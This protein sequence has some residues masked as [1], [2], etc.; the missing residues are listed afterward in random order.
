MGKKHQVITHYMTEH[1]YIPLWVLVN[2]LTFGK[3]TMFY[4]H[5]K[6][7]DRITVA[8]KFHVNHDELRK[9]MII[10]GLARNKC[11]HDERFYDFRSR[12]NIHTKSIKNFA[13]LGLPKDS[14]GSYLYGLND[15][16]SVAI[17]I[18]RLL[19]GADTREF[20]REM[21]RLFTTLD[22]GLHTIGLSDV[23]RVMGYPPN[24]ANLTML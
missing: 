10:L 6:N 11:A 16:F 13:V 24:W 1:G 5:M 2:V 21:S 7:A 8:R 17:I 23:M 15:S 4:T 18:S 9:Y 19:S 14:G 12:D 3:I 20:V 22:K